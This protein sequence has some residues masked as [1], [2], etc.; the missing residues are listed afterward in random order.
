VTV[1]VKIVNELGV[2]AY[3]LLLF[4]VLYRPTSNFWH[5]L[6]NDELVL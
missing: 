3:V 1:T 2:Q 5:G 4:L 6:I